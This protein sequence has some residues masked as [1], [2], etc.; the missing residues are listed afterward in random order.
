MIQKI[1]LSF[2][3]LIFWSSL[4]LADDPAREI[5]LQRWIGIE[6]GSPLYNMVLEAH[7]K[8]FKEIWPHDKVVLGI[9][10]AEQELNLVTGEQFQVNVDTGEVRRLL[11]LSPYLVRELRDAGLF[12]I[13]VGK[14]TVIIIPLDIVKD[15]VQ[16]IT[17]ASTASDRNLTTQEFL[18]QQLKNITLDLRTATGLT[19][20]RYGLGEGGVAKVVISV[21]TFSPSGIANGTWDVVVGI[22]GAAEDTV[23]GVLKITRRGI[24]GAITWFIELFR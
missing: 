12:F 2:V 5:D 18:T 13:D 24:K 17:P 8:E 14:D 4:T 23:F 9:R 6:V 7:D 21:F 20:K 22:E 11:D 19:T 3:S 15:L 16:S 1:F 10:K